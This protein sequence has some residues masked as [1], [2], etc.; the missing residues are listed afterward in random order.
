MRRGDVRL[1]AHLQDAAEVFLTPVV[2]G[3]LLFGF[4]G[5]RL[6]LENRDLLREFVDSP[7][8]AILAVDGETAERYAVIRSY[9]RQQ[10]RPIPVNDLW[11]AASAAQHSLRLLTLDEH[12]KHVPQVLLE[13]FAP[14]G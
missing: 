11:I 7:R 10:G 14:G 8:V 6:A 12:F 9:L 4:L 3:E 1:R 2:I 13:Y 5:G